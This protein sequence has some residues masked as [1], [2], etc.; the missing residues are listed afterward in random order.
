MTET[1]KDEQDRLWLFHSGKVGDS[2]KFETGNTGII[3]KKNDLYMVI[4]MSTGSTNILFK[5]KIHFN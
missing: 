1:K 5:D 2:L 4:K 3:K